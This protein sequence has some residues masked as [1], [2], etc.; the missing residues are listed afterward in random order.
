MKVS[1]AGVGER[2]LC[3]N[4]NGNLANLIDFSDFA[5]QL[6]DSTIESAESLCLG[7]I[8]STALFFKSRPDLESG[9]ARQI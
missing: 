8:R 3:G 2:V 9:L 7:S 6:P 1:K 5:I 4:G